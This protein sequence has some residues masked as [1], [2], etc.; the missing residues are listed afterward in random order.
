MSELDRCLHELKAEA[1]KLKNDN[2]LSDEQKAEFNADM[3]VMEAAIAN[4]DTAAIVDVHT[5]F[6]S[7]FPSLLVARCERLMA[8]LFEFAISETKNISDDAALALL[9]KLITSMFEGEPDVD[10]QMIS[11]AASV[12]LAVARKRQA[13][14]IAAQLDVSP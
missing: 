10:A 5:R 13:L 3:H 1:A 11:T 6:I 8:A 12:I 4:K 7:R 2:P 9:E 14:N